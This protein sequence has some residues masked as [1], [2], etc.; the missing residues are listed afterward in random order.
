MST[1][2]TQDLRPLIR[3]ATGIAAI[4]RHGWDVV[5]EDGEVCIVDK[6]TKRSRDFRRH[7]ERVFAKHL[8]EICDEVVE[9]ID[10]VEAIWERLAAAAIARN[11]RTTEQ[12][13]AMRTAFENALEKA[14]TTFPHGPHHAG[15][16]ALNKMLT[17]FGLQAKQET[18]AH[19]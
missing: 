15:Q 11:A 17:T 14:S 6:S 9:H 18:P 12:A 3:V 7:A 16:M 4:Q 5:V 10:A 19:D 8:G 1:P 13:V 2:N